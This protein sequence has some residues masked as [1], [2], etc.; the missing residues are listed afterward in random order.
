MW[1]H[2]AGAARRRDVRVLIAAVAL[3]GACSDD[4]ADDG[5]SGTGGGAPVGGASGASGASA[6][7]AGGAGG[8]SGGAAG[9]AAGRGGAG[10]AA[11]GSGGSGGG[12]GGG[13][14][15]SGA[16]GAG[17]A[18]GMGGGE[19]TLTSTAA[20]AGMMLPMEHRCMSLGGATG[21]SP[22][23]SWTGAP[24]GTMSFA[25]TLTDRTFMNY[26]HWT[27]WD[28]PGSV[29]MLA[30]GVPAGAMPATP[31]GAKQG[32]NSLGLSGPGY[33]GPCGSSSTPNMYEFTVHALDV[34]TLAGVTTSSTTAQIRMAIA[35]AEID[36]ASL[37][38]TSRPP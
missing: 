6:S 7:G 23:L 12:A 27:I 17:G 8:G 24:A 3:L 14:G 20:T 29:T 4:G 28:I 10:G 13:S 30:E 32:P 21:P 26:A 16:G 37:M 25:V 18:S 9:A 1:W 5:S 33:S 38:V 19:F 11:A 35:D 22:Q 34:A 31:S 15:A 36:T 2:R